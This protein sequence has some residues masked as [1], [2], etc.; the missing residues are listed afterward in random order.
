MSHL[1]QI[2]EPDEAAS[3]STSAVV[4]IDLGTTNSLVAYAN[5]ETVEVLKIESNSDLVPSLV[6]YGAEEIFVG[7]KAQEILLKDPSIVAVS[8]KRLLSSRETLNFGK[9]Q[10]T[11]MEVSTEILRYLKQ[12]AEAVLK[13]TIQK[14][15]ITVPAYFDERARTVTRDAARLAGLKV[16]RLVSEPTA[17]AL[18]YGLETGAEGIYA[19]YDL[20]GGTFD[21]SLL[22][23][24]K[25]IFRVL[26]TGGDSHLGGDDFDEALLSFLLND[27]KQQ[28]RKLAC[29]EPDRKSALVAVRKIKERLTEQSNGIWNLEYQGHSSE[30]FLHRGQ[31][32]ALFEPLV[33]KTIRI[34]HKVLK[35][36]GLGIDDI[37]GVV[38]VGGATR[39]P[40]VKQRVQSFFGQPGLC[41]IDP[42]RAVA[43]GAAFQAKALSQGSSSLLLDVTPLSLGLEIMGEVVEKIIYRNSP[44]PANKSQEFTTYQDGQTRMKI[45]VLQGEG[46]SVSGCR[47]LG[48]F[49]LGDIP[50][51]SAGVPRI[52]VNFTLDADGLLQVS[53]CEKT[54]GVQQSISIKPSYGLTEE[55]MLEL[56]SQK[57]P[58]P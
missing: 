22:S 28:L 25:G 38:L 50:P 47:S 56:L 34:C 26:A 16:L 40:L 4:G 55:E 9:R 1:L 13:K 53:A 42:D 32:D 17:A 46:E 52:N 45:H 58:K 36:A 44:I 11:P 14:A 33:E 27:C 7:N 3:E 21:L 54:T 43:M 35:D 8:T 5:Q 6:A 20:G 19:I 23:L 24:D 31:L 51:M 10:V 2:T 57:T 30:H 39:M 37:K 49:I 18:A 41:E 15:V 12:R 29:C 48:Q